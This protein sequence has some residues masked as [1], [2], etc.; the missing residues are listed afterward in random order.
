MDLLSKG[1]Q[2][3]LPPIDKLKSLHATIVFD[4]AVGIRNDQ[5][6]NSIKIKT[7]INNMI[8]A[9]SKQNNPSTAAFFSLRKRLKSD[10]CV[11]LKDDK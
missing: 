5:R 8:G 10:D 7:I 11:I 4:I 3:A 1:K 9:L 2:F 6:L